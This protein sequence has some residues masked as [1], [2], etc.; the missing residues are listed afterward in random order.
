MIGWLRLVQLPAT[1]EIGHHPARLARLSNLAITVRESK[2]VYAGL[3]G[4]RH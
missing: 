3:A 1:L 2:K 4:I